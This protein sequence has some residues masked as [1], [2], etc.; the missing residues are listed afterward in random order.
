M[1]D[2]DDNSVV[3]MLD[4]S[5]WAKRWLLSGCQGVNNWCEGADLD[6]LGNVDLVD[7][8]MFTACWLE[9]LPLE[10]TVT[11][12]DDD[13]EELNS[14]GNM[15]ITST[16]LELINDDD[17]AGGD[18]TI[19]LRF[20]NVNIEQGSRIS[21]AY[22][23]FTVDEVS[24]GTCSLNVMVEDTDNSTEF[25]SLA[26]NIS[27]REV[28]TSVAW[29]PPDWTTIGTS[30]SAQRTS[31]IATLIQ[32]IIDRPGWTSGNALTV[33]ISGSGRRTAVSFDGNPE[34]API[35]HIEF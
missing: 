33:I 16:D 30:D 11:S 20:T 12:S 3:D 26:Y 1:C 35:L 27:N 29:N 2:F 4:Y 32:Q 17:Y 34:M 15:Y 6:Q 5:F 22:I 10:V 31:D 7:L 24:T 8:Y 23:Q 14:D 25:T 9:R 19:G 28:T 21:N 18:Q 13:A